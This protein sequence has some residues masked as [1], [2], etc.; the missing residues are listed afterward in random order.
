[1]GRWRLPVRAGT[2]VAGCLLAGGLLLAPSPW[3]G[4]LT[5]GQF[6]LEP[7]AL[8][9]SALVRSDFSFV[10]EPGQRATDAVI[11]ANYAGEPQTFELYAADGYNAPV[12]GGLALRPAGAA[13]PSLGDWVH[14]AASRYTVPAHTVATVPFSLT[15]P[16]GARPGDHVGGIVALDLSATGT[17][18]RGVPVALRRGVAVAVFVRVL[19]P[20]HPAMAVTAVGDHVS[21]GLGLRQRSTVYARLANT[22]NVQLQATVNVSVTD[23]SGDTVERFAPQR[24][25][26]LVPGSS[27]TVQEPAFSP[28]Q[29]I[30]PEQVHVTVATDHAGTV[31]A[32]GSFWIVPWDG[33]VVLL[34]VLALG[35][36]R[37]RRRRRRARR[38]PT[39]GRPTTDQA[40]GSA[41]PASTPSAGLAPPSTE[42]ARVPAAAAAGGRPAASARR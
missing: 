36:W 7:I 38:G 33:V 41:G 2:A 37:L 29:P 9:G 8:P 31:T 12:G 22:G 32:S 26:V 40:G 11:V 3:A 24:L 42:G 34:A 21:A 23:L 6:S 5:A 27:F 35:G 28:S 14:L 13:G 4:A 20:L 1:M 17:M 15:V 10:L 18:G 25:P 30:G 16:H 39:S 19:G